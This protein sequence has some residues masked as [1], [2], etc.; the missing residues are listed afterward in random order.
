MWS[1]MFA[2]LERGFGGGVPL[3]AKE[4]SSRTSRSVF[5]APAVQS[6]RILSSNRPDGVSA[7]IARIRALF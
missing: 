4:D 5:I 7:Y 3:I 2:A 6:T 1:V